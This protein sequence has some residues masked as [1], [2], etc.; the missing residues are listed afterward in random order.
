M[1]STKLNHVTDLNKVL[2]FLR[3]VYDKAE[4]NHYGAVVIPR[5]VYPHFYD[6]LLKLENYICNVITELKS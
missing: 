4:I 2:S 1:D 6:E 3:E 5:D